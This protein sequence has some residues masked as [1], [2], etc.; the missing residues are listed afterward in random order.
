[1]KRNEQT[2]P[3][4]ASLAG[5][6]L[7]DVNQHILRSTIG[8]LKHDLMM[9]AGCVLTQAPNRPTNGQAKTKA[10]RLRVRKKSQ[11]KNKPRST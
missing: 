2:S 1:M 10:R 7:K 8:M 5:R 3:G 4:I 9:L 11:R 6:I